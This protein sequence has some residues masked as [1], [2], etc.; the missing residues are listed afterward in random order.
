LT[1]AV[2]WKEREMLLSLDRD[3]LDEGLEA[4][5][6]RSISLEADLEKLDLGSQPGSTLEQAVG[7]PR[8][9]SRLGLYIGPP[10]SPVQTWKAD[11]ATVLTIYIVGISK[12]QAFPNII[13]SHPSLPHIIVFAL[14]SPKIDSWAYKDALVKLLAALRLLFDQST[15]VLLKSGTTEHIDLITKSQEQ[16]DSLSQR[17]RS[18]SPPID[19][20]GSRKTVIPIALLL[21]CAFPLDESV[22]AEASLTKGSISNVLLSL[23]ALWPDSNP[24]R[25]ALKRVNE[26]LLGRDQ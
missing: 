2:F 4:A 15:K 26:V 3:E 10:I 20:V 19:P 7:A 22:A 23:V 13:Y 8:Q 14:P 17:L 9:T 18:L 21:L 16:D 1:P 5:K 25:A 24:P 11:S 6:S 12:A